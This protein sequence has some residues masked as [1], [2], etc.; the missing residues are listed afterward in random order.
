MNIDKTILETRGWIERTASELGFTLPELIKHI[1][2]KVILDLGSGGGGF[3]I[4]VAFIQRVMG[5]PKADIHSINP[6][7]GKPGIDEDSQITAFSDFKR[8]GEPL[9]KPKNPKEAKE[10]AWDSYRSRAVAGSWDALP[11]RDNFFDLILATGSYFYYRQTFSLQSFEE[12]LRVLKPGGE[13]R[14][15]T[16][17]GYEGSLERLKASIKTIRESH[18]ANQ[19]SEITLE[20]NPQQNPPESR[21]ISCYILVK[22]KEWDSKD[23]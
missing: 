19:I 23:Y 11:Y 8:I 14:A 21:N 4:D 1:E 15:S 13:F 5:F 17:Y 2:G 7:L 9:K 20:V 12:I 22:K 6:R 18:L 3:A 16:F 10:E